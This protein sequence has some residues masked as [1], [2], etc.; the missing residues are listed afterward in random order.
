L[1]A[2]PV[3]SQLKLRLLL[4]ISTPLEV[5]VVEDI[6]IKYFV[7]EKNLKIFKRTAAGTMTGGATVAGRRNRDGT[8]PAT[9]PTTHWRS[10]SHYIKSYQKFGST[11]FV[12]RRG[13]H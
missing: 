8:R 13:R 10:N 1:S 2:L 6:L 5:E 3:S 9:G 12:N 11:F 4:E 7:E